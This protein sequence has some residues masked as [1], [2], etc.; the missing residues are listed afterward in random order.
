[1]I[2]PNRDQVLRLLER[3]NFRHQ[4]SS[5]EEI[6]RLSYN[7]GNRK[8]EVTVYSD[9]VDFRVREKGKSYLFQ[10]QYKLDSF[11]GSK[12]ERTIKYLIESL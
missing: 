9:S 5:I 2:K 12:P 8:L 11:G 4:A 6:P 3:E 1:M 10:A 7:K